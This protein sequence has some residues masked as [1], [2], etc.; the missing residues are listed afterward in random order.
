M[1]RIDP[2]PS[3]EIDEETSQIL[4][5]QGLS[6][7][8]NIF[9]TIAH[10]PKLLR[11]WLVFG[12]HVLAKSTLPPR[13]RELVI[14]RTGYRCR[15]PYEW[16]HHVEIGRQVGI[17]DNEISLV[18]QGPT[19][20]SWTAHERALLTAADE[21]HDHSKLSDSTWATLRTTY[22][23]QQMLD[24]LFTIGQ[25]HMVSFVLNSCEVE[26]EPGTPAFPS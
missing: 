10:H 5:R 7:A 3:D 8:G 18:A 2:L 4:E 23:E 13:D 21:L 17:N 16:G 11:R 6:A 1:P 19:A 9:A 24:L 25:Y 26:V 20:P 15:A 14:L 22:D 12:A